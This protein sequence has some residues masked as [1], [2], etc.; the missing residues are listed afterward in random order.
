MLGDRIAMSQR[1]RDVLKVLAPVLAGTRTQAEAARL[2]D[3]S[4]RQVRRVQRRL[5]AEGDAGFMGV[6]EL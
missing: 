5:E 1:E 4:V 6:D 3:R 2:M